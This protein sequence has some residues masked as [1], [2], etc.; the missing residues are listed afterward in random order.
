MDYQVKSVVVAFE[1]NGDTVKKVEVAILDD[2]ISESTEYFTITIEPLVGD[3][4]FPINEAVVGITDNDGQCRPA[5]ITY[6]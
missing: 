5:C 2:L 4:T 3:V 6:T 1:G